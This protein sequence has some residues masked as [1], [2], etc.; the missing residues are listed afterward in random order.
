[1]ITLKNHQPK[2]SATRG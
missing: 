2:L 1:M